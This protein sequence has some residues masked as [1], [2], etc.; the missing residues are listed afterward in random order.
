MCSCAALHWWVEILVSCTVYAWLI[1]A[2]L[3]WFM[4]YTYIFSD[5][6]YMWRNL[7]SLACGADRIMAANLSVTECNSELLQRWG[8]HLTSWLSYPYTIILVKLTMGCCLMLEMQLSPDKQS[9]FS[10]H[11]KDNACILGKKKRA[12]CK[13]HGVIPGLVFFKRCIW[14]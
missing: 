13:L 9:W 1:I 8:K 7:N 10:I 5:E 6:L 14:Q 11:W 2:I 3:C 12:F 4:F